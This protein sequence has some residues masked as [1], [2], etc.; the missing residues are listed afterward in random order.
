M[1]VA[2]SLTRI[3]PE[4][5]DSL[6]RANS[7]QALLLE[8]SVGKGFLLIFNLEKG[9]Q[10]RIWDC[11]FNEGIEIYSTSYTAIE[12]TYFNL[13]FFLDIKE[14]LFANGDSI[15]PEDII[16]NTL[17]LCATS[18]Y[19]I[20]IPPNV[21]GRCLSISFSKKWLND[22]I[23]EGN[24]A[25]KKLK[26]K[27]D[28]SQPFSLLECMDATER[29]TVQ[30]LLANS[31]K[32]PFGTFYIKASVLKIVSDFFYRIKDRETLSFNNY[33]LDTLVV[34]VKN[35]LVEH[36]TGS[37]PD[38]KLLASKFSVSDSTLKRHFRKKYGV[39][40]STYFFQ[41]KMEYARQLMRDDNLNITETANFLGYRNVTHFF[42][43]LKKYQGYTPDK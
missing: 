19:K 4:K 12:N 22:N 20:Q 27:I 28:T 1:K 14:F 13:A 39:N 11:S 37:M 26:Q 36:L 21:V 23:L 33:C 9:L 41:K 2:Q 32:K 5:L 7:E 24:D 16:C 40:M 42:T 18:N 30:E 34:E 38:L 35:H 29:K 15:L 6:F 31:W 10:A 25:F 8:P 43:M 3:C 17:L